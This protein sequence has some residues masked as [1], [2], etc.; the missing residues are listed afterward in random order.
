M[1]SEQKALAH[2][3]SAL[4]LAAATAQRLRRPRRQ[5]KAAARAI[6][7]ATRSSRTATAVQPPQEAASDRCFCEG[8]QGDSK[9]KNAS[10]CISVVREQPQFWS[11]AVL[12]FN[13]L[14]LTH[15]PITRKGVPHRKAL[16]TDTYRMASLRA[17][18][19]WCIHIAR[20][21]HTAAVR[22]VR[23]LRGRELLCPARL[24][25]GCSNARQR[26]S[27][28]AAVAGLRLLCLAR[29]SA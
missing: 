26:C 19:G 29:C 7:T 16:P 21:T 14:I 15:D 27:T 22:Y 12:K 17:W 2:A 18:R 20:H 4:N 8:D 25:C 24:F 1:S 5:R 10:I 13:A 9:A 6:A 23:S 3:L 11:V 28:A